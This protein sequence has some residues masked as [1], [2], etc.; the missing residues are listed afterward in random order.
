MILWIILTLLTAVAAVVVAIPFIRH[1]EISH[2][3]E[4]QSLQVGRDQLDELKGDV[5]RG[6]I[7]KDE[8]AAAKVEIERRILMAAKTP[9]KGFSF[10][11]EKGQIWTLT[12]VVGW[13]VVGATG[14]YALIGRPELPSR[15]FIATAVKTQQPV[16]QTGNA[17][18]AVGE[19]D[20]LIAGL[21][22]RLAGNPDDAEGWR[23]LGWSYFN[24]QRY[25]LASKAYEKSVA[26]DASDPAVLAAYGETLVRAQKG[27]VSEKAQSVF[28][29]VLALNPSEPR[30]RFFKGMALEQS[31]NSKAA[32]DLWLAI[33]DDAPANADWIA[34][35]ELRVQELAA[36]SGYELGGRFGETGFLDQNS[37]SLLPPEPANGPTQEDINAAQKMTNEDRQAMIVGMVDKL[38]ARLEDNPNDVEGWMKLIRSRLVLGEKDAA[39]S[40]YLRASDVFAGQPLELSQVS[41]TARQLG[42]VPD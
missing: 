2:L 5:E 15:P 30:A 38:A 19:V 20:S 7:G 11:S 14:L 4:E 28:D 23:M 8:A 35:L 22:T 16:S 36:A 34:G 40:A 18:S 9:N 29:D 6:L 31:G 13:V 33:L 12:I 1:H 32:I 37:A 42:L 21:E 25:D 10:G 17:T 3:N 24:T 39:L 27:L 41:D 26:I